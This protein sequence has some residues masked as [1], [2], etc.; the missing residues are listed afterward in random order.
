MV[1]AACTGEGIP[2]KSYCTSGAHSP[3]WP[4]DTNSR[5]VRKKWQTTHSGISEAIENVVT[6]AFLLEITSRHFP[7]APHFS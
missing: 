4:Q 3:T 5:T 6:P 2:P 1:A 7:S